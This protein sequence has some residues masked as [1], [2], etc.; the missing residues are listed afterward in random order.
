MSQEEVE[1]L[2]WAT[3][4]D[5]EVHREGGDVLSQPYLSSSEDDVD[6]EN[7]E[8][9]KQENKGY[10][11][12]TAPSDSV[13]SAASVGAVPI[14]VGRSPS[15]CSGIIKNTLGAVRPVARRTTPTAPSCAMVAH[16]RST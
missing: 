8:D 3:N 13:G 16:V 4:D 1:D 9:S 11:A 15:A 2:Q 6:S 5:I 10:P 7:E 14:C 12:L